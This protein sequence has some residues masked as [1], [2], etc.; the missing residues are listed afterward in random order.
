MENGAI[1]KPGT[2]PQVRQALSIILNV[3]VKGCVSGYLLFGP[4]TAA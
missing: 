1:R 3:A 4:R 2:M